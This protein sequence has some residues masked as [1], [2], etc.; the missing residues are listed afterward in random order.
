MSKN[1]NQISKIT[2]VSKKDQLLYFSCYYYFGYNSIS[3]LYVVNM[4][5][6]WDMSTTNLCKQDSSLLPHQGVIFGGVKLSNRFK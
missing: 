6:Q 2:L 3:L 1:Q 5:V 4:Y